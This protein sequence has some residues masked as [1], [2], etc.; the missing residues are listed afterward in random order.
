MTARPPQLE[1]PFAIFN[2][3]ITPNDAFFVLLDEVG[4]SHPEQC[5]RLH[6][7][8]TGSNC[9]CAYQPLRCA[10]LHHEP[11]RRRDSET[12]R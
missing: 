6:A 11:A 4:L 5:L 7:S 8:G 2:G 3:V 10:F 12:K 1:T 9:N